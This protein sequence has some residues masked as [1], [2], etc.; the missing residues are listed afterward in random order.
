MRAE[1][2]ATLTQQ[3]KNNDTNSHAEAKAS[4]KLHK[5]ELKKKNHDFHVF[6]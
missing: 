5:S 3:K 6:Q 1:T 2:G 4:R